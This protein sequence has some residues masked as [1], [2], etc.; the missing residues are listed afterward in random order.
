MLNQSDFS[1]LVAG[2]ELKRS[3]DGKNGD[4]V[5]LD[6][7]EI[8]KIDRDIEREF[9]T[10]GSNRGKKR[11]SKGKLVSIDGE[12]VND[13]EDLEGETTYRDRAMERRKEE[14]QSVPIHGHDEVSEP[15]GHNVDAHMSATVV[16]GL[17]AEQT[18]YLGGDFEHTH[19][20]K[21]LDFAF[22]QK[23]KSQQAKPDSSSSSSSSS[24]S[25]GA[26]TSSGGGVLGEGGGISLP[27]VGIDNITPCSDLGLT[28]KRI[29]N[30]L[31][32]T[33]QPAST[34]AST[35]AVNP[36]SKFQGKGYANNTNSSTGPLPP[37]ITMPHLPPGI[38]APGVS[39][40]VQSAASTTAGTAGVAST[41]TTASHTPVLSAT[42]K[43]PSTTST[44][45]MQLFRKMVYQYECNFTS[46]IDLP[47]ITID[48]TRILSKAG[49][50]NHAGEEGADDVFTEVDRPM[51][52][53]LDVG[54]TSK[55]K[56]V[57]SSASSSSGISKKEKTYR[58]VKSVTSGRNGSG[59]SSGGSS[60][61]GGVRTH[62]HQEKPPK[63]PESCSIFDD[64]VGK[65]IPDIADVPTPTAP[66]PATATATVAIG[67]INSIF[68]DI[69]AGGASTCASNPA[70]TA[71][72]LAPVKSLLASTAQK[73]ATAASQSTIHAPIGVSNSNTIIKERDAFQL[74]SKVVK[75]EAF[76]AVYT[77]SDV[78]SNV[79]S[80]NRDYYD[81]DD[82]CEDEP[83]NQGAIFS[84]KGGGDQGEGKKR[85]KGDSG[86]SSSSSLAKKMRT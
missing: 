74:G 46:T 36:T 34:S 63:V 66:A 60:R 51:N 82:D 58:K 2:K 42:T 8:A 35:S 22:L 19:L 28:I 1:K 70:E 67:K 43:L 73:E 45:T 55:L 18:K 38:S 57:F 32:L 26:A 69:G 16:Q 24:S 10:G 39:K 77:S 23:V 13:D 59:G 12:S 44:P 72:L 64:V 84:K 3:I 5:R 29:F 48:N 56:N 65:Y 76:S 27:V 7:K 50:D 54:L 52:Y 79:D 81:S 4:K 83:R 41:R 17:T 31:A 86:M 61:S 71:D 85:S 25:G 20:V 11:Y 21:G 62:I 6:T 33:T 40:P 78:Y 68:D 47:A 9:T 80:I 49:G 75:G 14:N 37:G 30:Q 53:I 15:L